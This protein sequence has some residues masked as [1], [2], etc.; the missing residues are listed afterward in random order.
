MQTAHGSDTAFFFDQDEINVIYKALLI[1][2]TVAHKDHV[3]MIALA[4]QLSNQFK[5]YSDYAK[6]DSRQ[7]EFDF[8][9]GE[10][11]D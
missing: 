6:K 10:I 11:D 7:M 8:K 9:K 4:K 1:F 5:V 3:D 2:E